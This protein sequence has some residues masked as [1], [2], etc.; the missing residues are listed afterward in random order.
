MSANNCHQLIY[1]VGDASG[2]G[3]GDLFLTKDGLSYHIGIWNEKTSNQSF[4]YREF[5]NFLVAFK[6]E[7][8]A[9]RLANSFVI[10]KGTSDSPSLLEMVIEFHFLLMK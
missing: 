6:R 7:G 2:D 1:G 4:N 10:Y 9:G 8:E 3:F 5:R